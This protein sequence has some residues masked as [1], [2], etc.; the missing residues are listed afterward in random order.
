M[1]SATAGDRAA[2]LLVKLVETECFRRDY[3]AALLAS[4]P[5]ELESYLRAELAMPLDRQLR[6]AAFVIG[7]VPQLSRAAVRLR[8]EVSAVMVRS[9]TTADGRMAR[10]GRAE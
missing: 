9:S 7:N 3:L 6:L 4:R 2:R 5:E 10:F 1:P 8:S